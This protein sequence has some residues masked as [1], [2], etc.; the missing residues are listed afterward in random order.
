[1]TKIS[2]PGLKTPK[3]TKDEH[4]PPPVPAK[5]QPSLQ[6]RSSNVQQQIHSSQSTTYH[7][8]KLVALTNN[9]STQ[10]INL[11]STHD[12]NY[13]K[14]STSFSSSNKDEQKETYDSSAPPVLARTG[15]VAI[16]TRVLPVFD[17]NGDGPPV[18][19]RHLETE[20]KG[21]IFKRQYK[22]INKKVII[23]DNILLFSMKKFF[24]ILV[25][26]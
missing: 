26:I 8:S 9:D 2:K 22:L 11:D 4:L 17:P 19:L 13:S 14:S 15:K 6:T 20:K 3:T 21:K 25:Y 12:P 10:T 1:M 24:I 23:E 16:G 7:T 18:R 5:T